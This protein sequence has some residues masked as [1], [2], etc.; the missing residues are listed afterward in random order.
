MLV[1]W[2]G[3]E[4]HD[5]YI[6]V[7]QSVCQPLGFVSQSPRAYQVTM[8]RRIQELMPTPVS[9]IPM[10]RFVPRPIILGVGSLQ[11]YIV[12]EHR[13]PCHVEFPTV[14][15]VLMLFEST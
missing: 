1:T 14:Q 8:E 7:S 4:G 13:R 5:V 11:Q 3:I 12:S 10:R 9:K 15:V 2:Y 6:R